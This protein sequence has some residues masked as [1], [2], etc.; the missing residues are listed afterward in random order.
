[1]TSQTKQ[2]KKRWQMK[3]VP[4]ELQTSIWILFALYTQYGFT[5]RE[6]KISFLKSLKILYVKKMSQRQKGMHHI[7]KLSPA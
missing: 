4:V 3:R 5:K 7:G 1:M 6:K 2:N